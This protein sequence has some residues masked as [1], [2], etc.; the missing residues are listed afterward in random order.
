MIF[1]KINRYT[2]SC[3]DWFDIHSCKITSGDV[4]PVVGGKHLVFTTASKIDTIKLDLEAGNNYGYS[5]EK[6]TEIDLYAVLYK[7]WESYVQTNGWN[8][9]VT[10]FNNL[11]VKNVWSL[12]DASGGDVYLP[13]PNQGG[14]LYLLPN[15]LDCVSQIL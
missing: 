8:N 11:K 12:N 6:T 3:Y 15:Q 9:D 14:I 1:Y 5:Y 2:E 10:G 4:R 13:K 7:D